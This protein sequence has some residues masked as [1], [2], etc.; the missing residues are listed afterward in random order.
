[1][2]LFAAAAAVERL[3]EA[4][5]NFFESIL[6]KVIAR[7]TLGIQWLEWAQLEVVSAGNAIDVATAEL[8]RL[9][10]VERK[11]VTD[12]QVQ[13]QLA[14]LDAA[15]GWLRDS[16]KRMQDVTKSTAY[17]RF[18]QILS[19]IAGVVLGIVVAIAANLDVLQMLGLAPASLLGAIATGFIVG[20]GSAWVHS[21]FGIVEQTRN[22]IDQGRALANGAALRQAAQAIATTATRELPPSM[23]AP[24]PTPTPERPS[25][26]GQSPMEMPI[27]MREM[28]VLER[29]VGQ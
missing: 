19:L 22:I 24:A 25:D 7:L 29:M 26:T 9:V 15:E 20:T 8:S 5:F 10:G 3:L 6:L 4:A 18:K 27:S 12:P 28:R 16:Q 13:G 2:P 17:L 21:L 1:M 11:P 23:V 14:Q